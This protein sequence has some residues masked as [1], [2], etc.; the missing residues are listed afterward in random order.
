MVKRIKNIALPLLFAN[1]EASILAASADGIGKVHIDE[2]YKRSIV[3][4]PD[5]AQLIH[6]IKYPINYSTGTVN[7]EIPLFTI[8]CGTLSV[9]FYLTYD[10]SG[11]KVNSPSGWVG[12]NWLLNGIPTIGRQV[13]GHI[14]PGL[15]CA[16]DPKRYQ[17]H[18]GDDNYEHV[19]GL[20]ANSLYN[21]GV[22][23][24]PDEYYFNI[25][26]QSGM[27]MYC[28][29]PKTGYP[30]YMTVPYSNLLIETD[31][32]K[33][34]FLLT[35]A[36]GTTY[37][38]SGGYD[39]TYAPTDIYETGRKASMI[40]AANGLDSIVFQYSGK[41]HYDME[42]HNDSYTV[43]DDMHAC[44]PSLEEN[45]FTQ[46]DNYWDAR[47]HMNE[48]DFEELVKRPIIIKTTNQKTEGFQVEGTYDKLKS[49]QRPYDPIQWEN[50]MK[51]ES[52]VLSSIHFKGNTVEFLSS[53]TKNH[54]R[55]EKI[56]LRNYL[57]KVVKTITFD[58]LTTS[59]YYSRMYLSAVNLI[60]G[61]GEKITY[62]FTY[63]NPG[64]GGD[65]GNRCID[66]W[67]YF[68]GRYNERTLVPKTKVKTMHHSYTKRLEFV[69]DSLMIG[70]GD[71]DSRAADEEK[72]KIGS[73]A[74]VTYPT[75]VRDSFIYE[76][77]QIRLEYDPE[78]ETEFH[79][80]EHLLNATG[81]KDIY[82][83]GGL[84][85][86]Q[87]ISK[88]TDGDANVRSFR[89][90]D[91]GTGCSPIQENYNYFVSEKT[92]YYEN[93]T[94]TIYW[95]AHS[96]YRTYSSTPTLPITYENGAPVMYKKVT[97]YMGTAQDNE[98]FTT[99]EYDVPPYKQGA[100]GGEQRGFINEHRYQDWQYGK[101]RSKT[102]Y[103]EDGKI[104]EKEE[105][106][107]SLM[108]PKGKNYSSQ[109]HFYNIFNYD[110][111]QTM[112]GGVGRDIEYQCDKDY[113]TM[114]YDIYAHELTSNTHEVYTEEEM[115][116]T[117]TASDYAK[118]Y[119]NLLQKESLYVNGEI[120]QE[121]SYEYPHTK[122]DEVYRQMASRHI[123]KPIVATTYHFQGDQF[124]PYGIVRVETPYENVSGDE[125]APIFMPTKAVYHYG[126]HCETRYAWLY[127]HLGQVVQETKDGKEM[128]TYI[129]GYNN[130]LMVGVIQNAS[131]G[132][133]SPC[134]PSIKSIAN[135]PTPLAYWD[136]LQALRQRLSN[137]RVTLYK[138]EPL[139]GICTEVK[140]NGLATNYRYDGF[141]RLVEKS[142]L[143]K[144]ENEKTE[145]YKYKYK[146]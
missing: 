12:Q 84:R 69:N 103:S 95:Y 13:N 36:N 90:G 111:F 144:G 78:Y 134:L 42:V 105:Y 122:M 86:K 33:K 74:S 82:Q 8:E 22:E 24:Q 110:T 125:S 83:A 75:G 46:K 87:I 71:W 31:E 3:T 41:L 93:V 121:N 51:L 88:T 10:T 1:I 70:H 140:P 104:L 67:G 76:A 99:Y 28:L 60:S 15:Q 23:E 35:D 138:H 38:F 32:E 39:R 85:I 146:Q 79:F 112:G 21:S 115:M 55:L 120:R 53:E 92:K 130:Q 2:L 145:S 132:E 126:D 62:R 139:V 18:T 66:F 72:M 44:D 5:M 113:V 49:D 106:G 117:T 89:Y 142:I 124:N 16:F 58:Y 131:L 17:D 30:Q 43:I 14:D 37:D 40:K 129:Y 98:G 108:G 109:Y 128:E 52:D 11:I 77:N 94:P 20:L 7:I 102:V 73:L 133:I 25:G 34:H 118:D 63:N 56:T 80:S 81:K 6:N 91:D 100:P 123:L 27:F 101:L 64:L 114:G 50:K 137:A 61:N 65:F 135:S 57:G 26:T 54:C 97:E 136:E 47:E 127:N 29:Q 119:T 116:V 143:R 107:Y 4:T 141:G 96:R 45:L 19:E 48:M 9:P 68:N 59:N